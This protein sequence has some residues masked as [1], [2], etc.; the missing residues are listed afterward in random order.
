MTRDE[1]IRRISK[2]EMDEIFLKQEFEYVANKLDLTVAQLQ[3]IFEGNNKTS[4]DYKNKRKLI[5]LGA[6]AMKV[7]GLE[8]RL[9]R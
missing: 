5:G 1:A 4:A 7:L 2:P 9:F 6:T 3:E 8:K